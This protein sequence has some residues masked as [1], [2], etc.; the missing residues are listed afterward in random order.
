M[1]LETVERY[2]GTERIAVAEHIQ[3]VLEKHR[4]RIPNLAFNV[5]QYSPLPYLLDAATIKIVTAADPSMRGIRF[6]LYACR[7]VSLVIF[8]L[9]LL[10]SF[11]LFRQGIWPVLWVAATPMAL[12]QA[13]AVNT[14][15]LV[16]AS[17]FLLFSATFGRWEKRI[18][19]AALAVSIFWLLVIK[20]PYAILSI[21]CALS[22]L[23]LDK[24]RRIRTLAVFAGASAAGVL[25][26]VF[27]SYMMKSSGA[28]QEMLSGIHRYISGKI[29]P[30]AQAN[31]LIHHPAK[32]L[33]VIGN[34]LS[35]QGA[36]LF[37]QF[38]GVLGWLDTPIPLW[39]AVL[40][41]GCVVPA[42]LVSRREDS[43]PGRGSML[44]GISCLAS[45][46]LTAATIFAAL[47]AIW[48]PVGAPV[49]NLQ[50]RY[51]E[52]VVALVLIGLA[53]LKSFDMDQAWRDKGRWTLILSAVVIHLA[54]FHAVVQRWP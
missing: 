50:G 21:P 14:D 26:I 8:S 46:C 13:A 11:R 18:S 34:T 37:H 49:A 41:A 30:V 16:N 29:D 53:S 12:S 32:L 51:F 39:S 22:V 28:Y 7:L 48:A 17:A 19:P 3:S 6:S 44:L 40:W 20:P 43:W 15:Y 36:D 42:V 23:F 25:E 4:G 38:V 10:L 47:Y 33:Q 52:P 5:V 2:H 27:W 54:S 31:L 1:F 45:A 9:A 24:E 35:T